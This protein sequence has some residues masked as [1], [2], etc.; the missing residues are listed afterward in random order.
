MRGSLQSDGTHWRLR[1]LE[2]NSKRRD[3]PVNSS[4]EHYL[5]D[6]MH[7]AGIDEAPAGSPLFRSA[8]GKS[9]RLNA[10]HLSGGDIGRMV[11]RR[12]LAAGLPTHLSPHSFRVAVATDLLKQSVALEDVQFLLG[13]SDPRTTRLYDRRHREVTRNIVERIGI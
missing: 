4:F 8:D 3:I 5:L 9:G 10:L 11:K 1:F 12:L 7:I 6:Y 13:H 2:K